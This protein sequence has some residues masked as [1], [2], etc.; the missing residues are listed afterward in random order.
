MSVLACASCGPPLVGS[1]FY[2][3]PQFSVG[4]A[5]V[6]V[7]SRVPSSHGR[8]ELSVLWVGAAQPGSQP[9][10][11]QAQLDSELGAFTMTLFD[12]PSQAASG[13]SD[14]V[15][16]GQLA[17][18]VI[19]LY[20][21]QNGSGALEPAQDLLLGASAQHVV[22]YSEGPVAPQE[23]A[24]ELVGPLEAGYHL[25]QLDGESTCRLV[26]ATEC[27]GQ[28]KLLATSDLDEVTLSLWGTAE[29]VRVPAPRR[30][31]SPQAESIWGP[32][33]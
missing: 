17:V 2:G 27:Q 3:T 22:V 25:L 18:G 33:P 7:V 28:G 32:T 6:S 1:N 29:E 23:L 10:E 30:P 31:S 16:E 9:V 12:P 11:Q 5:V 14:L 24:A 4:G 15:N 20:A 8:L 19:V 26:Q 21:D 13:F